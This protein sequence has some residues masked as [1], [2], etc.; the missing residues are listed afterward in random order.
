MAAEVPEANCIAIMPPAI[1]GL[2]NAG[3][4]SMYIQDRS[5]GTVQFLDQNVQNFLAAARKRPELTGV[6]SQFNSSVPQI[7][8]NVDR[9][10]VLKQGEAIGDVNQTLQ[11]YLAGLYL[12]QFN[13]FGSQWRWFPLVVL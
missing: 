2:G 12:N 4:F 6:T 13:R 1:P 11:P 3:G 8:P 9:D 10:K 5:G 7:Y